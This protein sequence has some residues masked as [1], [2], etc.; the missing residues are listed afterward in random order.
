MEAAKL[1]RTVL[2][3]LSECGV[4]NLVEIDFDMKLTVT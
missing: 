3:K 2:I 4:E 1:P